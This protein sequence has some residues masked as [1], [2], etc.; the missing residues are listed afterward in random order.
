MESDVI[1]LDRILGGVTALFV[2]RVT[3]C[4]N[5]CGSGIMTLGGYGFSLPLAR[6]FQGW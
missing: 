3:D 6:I 2:A 4:V 5:A 1:G